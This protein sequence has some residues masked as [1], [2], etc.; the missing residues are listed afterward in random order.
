MKQKEIT[1]NSLVN[2]ERISLSDMTAE[3]IGNNHVMTSIDTPMKKD[4]FIMNDD[5]KIKKIESHFK[6]IMET[7]GLDLNDDSLAGTPERVAKMY[8]KE[9]FSGLNPANKPKIA[10]FENRYQYNQM[11]VEKDITFYSNCE[12]HF[13]PIFGK[14][15]LAYISNG[16]VIGLSK[17]N[18]IVQYFAKRP[19]VQERFTMQIAKELQKVLKTEDVAVIIDA[20]HL[21]VSSRG[22]QDI[23]AAT[24]TSF[25]GGKFLEENTK[26]EFLRYVEM[27]TQY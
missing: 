12:H 14:A 23:N 2:G 15:H 18:R 16:K 8:V 26:Q 24:I 11:L 19:Q 22:I 7:L 4:A 1:L 3:E 6:S 13:V 27:K 10:L 20:K 9:I 21:C 25:Y 17:L 5:E